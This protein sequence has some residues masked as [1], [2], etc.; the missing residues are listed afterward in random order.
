MRR[1]FATL[2]TRIRGDC[3]TTSV[4]E[5]SVELATAFALEVKKFDPAVRKRPSAISFVR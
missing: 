5:P 2:Q 3:V 1:S 4:I